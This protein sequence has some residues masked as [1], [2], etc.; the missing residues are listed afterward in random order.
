MSLHHALL[1]QADRLAKDTDPS[2]EQANLRRA[3]SS[4]YYA[5]FHLLT[6]S[7]SSMFASLFA[8]DAA[9]EPRISRSFNHGEM[10]EVSLNIVKGEWPKSTSPKN[11]P[12]ATPPDLST[13]ATAFVDL[14]VAR[15]T[16]DYDLTVDFERKEAGELVDTARKAFEAWERIKDT[17]DARLYLACFLLYKQWNKER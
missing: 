14:Q 4:A 7:A 8:I 16:A 5:L 15:H 13:V 6:S 9:L 1:E 3:V 12:R 10:K 17:D 2:L 11:S